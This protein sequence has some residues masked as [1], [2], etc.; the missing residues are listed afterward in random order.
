MTMPN[1]VST[2]RN[3]SSY[4]S[5]TIG[6]RQGE[7]VSPILFSLYLNDLQEYFANIDII[8]AKCNKMS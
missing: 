4:F 6:I 2:N 5:C 3:K 7:N 8:G 1:L